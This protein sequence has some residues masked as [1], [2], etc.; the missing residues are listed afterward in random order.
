MIRTVTIVPAILTN[1]KVDYR[2]QIERIN[3]YAK[4]IQVDVTDGVFAPNPTL[5]VVNVWW[6]NGWT[7]DLHMMVERPSQHIDTILKLKPALCIFHAEA[8]ENLLP[9]FNMLKQNGIRAGLALLPSTFPGTVEPYIKEA[10]HVL[11]FAGKLGE[12]GGAAD[13]MQMEKI[14]LVRNIKAE[15]EIGWDGGA[16][17]TNIRALAH[18]DLDVINVGS[19]L[20]QAQ[21][22][23]NVYQEMVAELDKT[24][25]VL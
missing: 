23:A 3:M 8:K 5:D 11:I 19:A 4:R 9:I 10:D 13:M 25:V 2:S 18:A 14:P 1:N 24:G 22:P 17:M 12:Q 15:V 21:N 16:N 6:P 20:S 7:V